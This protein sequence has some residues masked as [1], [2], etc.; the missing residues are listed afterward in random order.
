[1][2]T[3]A[4]LEKPETP[5]TPEVSTGNPV[6]T[7]AIP[8]RMKADSN[9][10]VVTV[11][12]LDTTHFYDPRQ[13]RS[14]LAVMNM[15]HSLKE[16]GQLQ[17]IGGALTPTG[18]IGV[19]YGFTRTEAFWRNITDKLIDRWNKDNNLSGEARFK[20]NN[21]QHRD[22]VIKAYPDD[23]DK[24]KN[25]DQNQIK[26]LIHD[27]V[28]DE[29]EAFKKSL[30]ENL[31]RNDMVLFDTLAGMEKLAEFG[32][33]GKDI[34]KIYNVSAPQVTN[35]RKAWRLKEELYG[36]LTKPEKHETF[37]ETDLVK[38]KETAKNL[39]D[40]L[41]GRMKLQPV[42]GTKEAGKDIRVS[43]SHLKELS[44]RVFADTPTL[45][46]AQM[47]IATA[48]LVHAN[49]KTFKVV[50]QD[51]GHPY[52]T[53]PPENFG[54]FVQ[55]LKDMEAEEKLRREGKA[56]PVPAT[57]P[58]P[59]AGKDGA[60]VPAGQQAGTVEGLAAAQKES[61]ATPGTTTAVASAA[62]PVSTGKSTEETA[63][64]PTA[65]IEEDVADASLKAK[66]VL[67]VQPGTVPTDDDVESGLT[68][69][70]L[71]AETKRKVQAA[72]AVS[73][74]V[75]DGNVI[76]SRTNNYLAMAM[77]E[78]D[79][80]V[81]TNL[82]S[83]AANLSAAAF[84]FDVL[85]LSDSEKKVTKA[86]NQYCDDLEQYIMALEEYAENATKVKGK[87][88]KPFALERPVCPMIP[89]MEGTGDEGD[90]VGEEADDDDVADDEDEE[91]DDLDADTPSEE[92]LANI[93]NENDA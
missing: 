91:G 29:K 87:N 51:E 69:A 45:S 13:E 84:G 86:C 44:A 24:E 5:A 23:F 28:K 57:G 21:K 40:C 2:S 7:Q 63:A 78:E 35:L 72:P 31:E 70:G 56:V 15:C 61:T 50:G 79:E 77:E 38:L 10:I 62:T 33:L 92:D 53:E 65:D 32:F 49:E 80:E 83:I 18:K 14:D 89:G 20:A 36:L 12:Q 88:L 68:S 54:V 71:T 90:D 41:I 52:G 8:Q 11:D 4:T 1:M 9:A 55:R 74:K 66:Q 73:A 43:I 81:N 42:S 30:T 48:L 22:I 59:E 58:A 17:P 27:E 67:G 25:K 93:E 47:M 76:L 34:A 37:T 75:K 39:V 6:A 46:R 64:S 85:S 3:S 60:T 26:V 19:I 82:G 16:E